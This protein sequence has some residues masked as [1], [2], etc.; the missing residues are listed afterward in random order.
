ML[1][2]FGNR[3]QDLLFFNPDEKVFGV[4]DGKNSLVGQSAQQCEGIT[5]TLGAPIGLDL[6]HANFQYVL[7]SLEVDA[8][9]I[10]VVLDQEA[11]HHQLIGQCLGVCVLLCQ[12]DDTEEQLFAA[13]YVFAA[14]NFVQLYFAEHVQED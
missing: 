5:K 10:E 6:P 4:V 1:I 2:G 12:L 3:G 14:V 13:D 9:V 11:D 7:V 8:G